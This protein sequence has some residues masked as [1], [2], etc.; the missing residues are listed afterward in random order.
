MQS[1]FNPQVAPTRLSGLVAGVARN[2][3]EL[4]KSEGQVAQER[5]LPSA[6][7]AFAGEI[8]TALLPEEGVNASLDALD[9]F[10]E[11][12]E[13]AGS[14]QRG[15]QGPTVEALQRGLN[16]MGATP[17]L[18]AD[19]DYGARTERA[20]RDFQ[21]AT[22]LE[23]TGVA[24]P[25]TTGAMVAVEHLAAA[26]LTDHP[27]LIAMYA[28]GA[29]AA[30][31]SMPEGSVPPALATQVAELVE[32][33]LVLQDPG[34]PTIGEEALPE[35]APEIPLDAQ[36]T[37]MPEGPAA[38]IEEAVAVVEM[39]DA[40]TGGDSDGLLALA[41]PEWIASA[42]R[43]AVA[44]ALEL[45]GNDFWTDNEEAALAGRLVA[46]L[47]QEFPA[48]LPTMW[49]NFQEGAGGN[50][51]R[52]F[53]DAFVEA[54]GPQHRIEWVAQSHPEIAR[55]MAEATAGGLIRGASPAHDRLTAALDWAQ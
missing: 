18:V 54:M 39:V 3:A 33:N 14:L 46:R 28:E 30:L 17:A 29:Q 2:A 25:E 53:S 24:G 26:S 55:A 8:V 10:E 48:A 9:A 50:N 23:E 6:T 34:C 43:E 21:R 47:T 27:S 37:M 20:V 4:A 16:A 42:P 13:F 22:G 41:T 44:K 7:D 32:R 45:M 36:L 35:A 31:A 40:E 51:L 52:A 12:P 5:A 38:A 49:A 11:D 1:N 19:G 15:S